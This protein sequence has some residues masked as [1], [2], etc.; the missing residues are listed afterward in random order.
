[1]LMLQRSVRCF[2]PCGKV[3]KFGADIRNANGGIPCRVGHHQR[4]E[5]SFIK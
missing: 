4:V 2:S 3:C 1:M 5:Q